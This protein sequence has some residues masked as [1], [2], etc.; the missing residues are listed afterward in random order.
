[1]KHLTDSIIQEYLD[2]SEHSHRTAVENH[3]IVCFECREKLEQYRELY[4]Q[5][6]VETEPIPD[7]S[8]NLSVL[9][10]I[11]RLEHKRNKRKLASIVSVLAG[12]SLLAMSL[13]FFDFISWTETFVGAKAIL[14]KAVSPLYETASTLVRELDGNLEL[15]AFAALALMLFQL[16][17]YGLI[18]HKVNRT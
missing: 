12:I 11:G 16:L 13:T 18:R 7:V 1:M 9:A 6:A 10:G 5:L 4:V 17:D 2:S 3:A 8:L 15:L 14:Y